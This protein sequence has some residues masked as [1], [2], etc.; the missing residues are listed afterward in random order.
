MIAA[1]YVRVGGNA[2]THLLD[3]DASEKYGYKAWCG[4]R[5]EIGS[6][7]HR[8]L[9]SREAVERLVARLTCE[10]CKCS[11]KVAKLMSYVRRVSEVK[12]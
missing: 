7:Q 11:R 12:P 6:V 4:S 2:K 8:P 5:P 1:V 9:S 10:R 3:P